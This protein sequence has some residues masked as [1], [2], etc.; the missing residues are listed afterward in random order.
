MA[1]THNSY[2]SPVKTRVWSAPHPPWPDSGQPF[3][4]RWVLRLPA[5]SGLVANEHEIWY[6]DE[7]HKRCGSEIANTA[8]R[9]NMEQQKEE[10]V[11]ALATP[12]VTACFFPLA[13]AERCVLSGRVIGSRTAK[14]LPSAELGNS[15]AA[16]ALRRAYEDGGPLQSCLFA[17]RNTNDTSSS[18]LHRTTTSTTTTPRPPK[19]CWRE[20]CAR[21]PAA[22][23]W[24]RINH[25]GD[26]Q[27]GDAAAAYDL[28]RSGE[29]V[30]GAP[31]AV[32]GFNDIARSLKC[33]DIA[34]TTNKQDGWNR[35]HQA[36]PRAAG[37]SKRALRHVPNPQPPPTSQSK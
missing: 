3:F 9:L 6:D 1:H 14:L 30:H 16:T 24:L 28:E 13:A 29:P 26:R 34:A 27:G 7:C 32:H 33:H 35:T 25:Y 17:P 23:S 22:E 5:P 36:R 15:T 11:E 4:A 12:L 8:A 37:A 10:L 21:G 20:A 18:S 19:G 2:R 31:R